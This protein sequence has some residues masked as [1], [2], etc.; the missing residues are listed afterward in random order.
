MGSSEE[1]LMASVSL[2]VSVIVAIIMVISLG[3]PWDL[4]IGWLGEQEVS[5][6]WMS[7]IQPLFGMFYALVLLWVATSF[8]WLIKTV[9]KRAEYTAGYDQGY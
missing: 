6:G 3:P 2:I 9:V 4:I 8:V 5:T 7:T 1:V